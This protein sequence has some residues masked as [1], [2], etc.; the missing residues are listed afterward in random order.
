MKSF[1]GPKLWY[2]RTKFIERESLYFLD[3]FTADY[4]ILDLQKCPAY[5][6]HKFKKHQ[7]W[8]E[9]DTPNYK[10]QARLFLI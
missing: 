5:K 7:P 2:D 10:K 9:N 3:I 8:F 6:K 4:A 1:G